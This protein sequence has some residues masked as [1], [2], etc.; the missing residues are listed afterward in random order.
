MK[1]PEISV[2]IWCACGRDAGVLFSPASDTDISDIHEKTIRS[3]GSVIFDCTSC[4]LL[5][6][7]AMRIRLLSEG[8]FVLKPVY[9]KG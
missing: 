1:K 3:I 8:T 4:C 2:R 9:L 6:D 5:I 7:S